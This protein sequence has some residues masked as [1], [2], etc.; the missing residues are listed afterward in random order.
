MAIIR[1][2]L[3]RIILLV[4]F[5]FR[6]KGIKRNAQLQGELDKEIAKL[7]LYQYAACPFCV[8]V[9]WSMKRNSLNIETKDA[10]RN[11]QYAKELVAGGGNLKVPCLK[12][13]EKDGSET[14]MYE[15]SDI[16]AYLEQRFAMV[17]VS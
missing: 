6:P 16:I 1:W 15:S 11:S 14:W 8:K 9:R 10:K 7:S 3:G 17:P 4:D 12:I 2:V 13:E 5:F